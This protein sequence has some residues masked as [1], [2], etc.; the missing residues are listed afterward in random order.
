[1][2]I[3]IISLI[4][5]IQTEAI[6]ALGVILCSATKNWQRNTQEM[7][8]NVQEAMRI[9]YNAVK[10]FLG[11]SSWLH[12]EPVVDYSMT[13]LRL[14]LCLPRQVVV[15]SNKAVMAHPF[16]VVAALVDETMLATQLLPPAPSLEPSIESKLPCRKGLGLPC[17]PPER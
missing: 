16:Q 6:S 12:P 11:P 17:A 7:L 8:R 2:E 1:M 10:Q 5:L 14:F 15:W 3:L 9:L 13:I 4:E